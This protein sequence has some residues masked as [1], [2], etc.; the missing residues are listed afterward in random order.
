MSFNKGHWF[1]PLLAFGEFI[2][3]ICLLV[4]A[5]C[6]RE[7]TDKNPSRITETHKLPKNGSAVEPTCEGDNCPSD[8]DEPADDEENYEDHNGGKWDSTGFCATAEICGCGF[9]CVN[10]KCHRKDSSCC[11]DT[12]CGAGLVCIKK[13][14]E[15]NGNCM[16]SQCDTD[17]QCGSGCGVH[18]DN[19]RCNQTRCCSNTDCPTGKYCELFASSIESE[20]GIQGTCLTRE[21]SSSVDCGCGK[22]CN[23]HSCQESWKSDTNTPPYQCCGTDIFYRGNCLSHEYIENGHCVGNEHCP[24]G[25]VC[26]E[27]ICLPEKCANN[28]SCGC[29]G[30]CRKGR[31]ERGCEQNSDCCNKGEVC[32]HN[33]CIEPDTD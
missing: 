7:T 5:D 27:Y 22:F 9:E 11:T 21:C 14:D 26:D 13:D 17:E 15:K 32:D 1:F 25:K 33:R 24:A 28:A 2:F 18:C 10:N 8:T 16:V 19:H 30:V 23:G 4:P 12:D 31:C 29:E 3:I 20:I 6:G